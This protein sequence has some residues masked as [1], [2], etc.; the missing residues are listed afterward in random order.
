MTL[1]RAFVRPPGQGYTFGTTVTVLK[2]I[3]TVFRAN[4][5]MSHANGISFSDN[6]TLP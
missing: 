3:V 2:I 6:A 1:P 4:V 5:I